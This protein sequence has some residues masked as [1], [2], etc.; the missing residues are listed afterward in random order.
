MAVVERLCSVIS[1]LVITLANFC[2][3]SKTLMLSGTTK[4]LS[5][6]LSR[7]WSG[8]DVSMMVILCGRVLA[9]PGIKKLL[10]T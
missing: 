8:L 2:C 10:R 1:L 5:Q 3:E 7:E 9:K 6:L 4:T